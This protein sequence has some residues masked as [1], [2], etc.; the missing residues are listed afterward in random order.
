VCDGLGRS[1]QRWSLPCPVEPLLP[2]DRLLPCPV[3]LLLQPDR[4]LVLPRAWLPDFEPL[5]L[6]DELAEEL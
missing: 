1:S 6:F 5:E 3:V 2:T 4:L